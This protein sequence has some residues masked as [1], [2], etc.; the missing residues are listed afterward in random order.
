MYSAVLLAISLPCFKP[1]P[2]TCNTMC[3]LLRSA[4]ETAILKLSLT[5][6][7]SCSEVGTE[8]I[9]KIRFFARLDYIWASVLDQNGSKWVKSG[10]KW[11][12]M[13]KIG[14]NFSRSGQKRPK[15]IKS[16]QNLPAV[17]KSS[18]NWS[19]LAKSSQNWLKV[20]MAKK[21][22]KSSKRDQHITWIIGM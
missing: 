18:Q 1:L 17:A 5:C 21:G 8:N 15:R 7:R 22:Q 13:T 16:G 11:S 19:K 9:N 12:N 3:P 20:K 6:N 4:S 14:L 10:Q 2:A